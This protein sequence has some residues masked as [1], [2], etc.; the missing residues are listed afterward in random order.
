MN[1][2]FGSNQSVDI[3]FQL[4]HGSCSTCIIKNNKLNFLK[5]FLKSVSWILIP[6]DGIGGLNL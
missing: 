3:S 5:L 1:V 4:L 6:K 2:S